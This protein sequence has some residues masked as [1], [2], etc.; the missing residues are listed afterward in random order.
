[1]APDATGLRVGKR[2]TDRTEVQA[3]GIGGSLSSTTGTGQNF[4]RMGRRRRSLI[5]GNQ[6]RGQLKQSKFDG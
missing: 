5:A 4:C 6:A 2:I 1:M 3:N